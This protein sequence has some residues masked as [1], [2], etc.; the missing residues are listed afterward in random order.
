MNYSFLSIQRYPPLMHP[1]GSIYIPS[2]E[3]EGSSQIIS[4]HMEGQESSYSGL[5]EENSK[6]IIFIH[7]SRCTQD[8]ME[9]HWLML[10]FKFSS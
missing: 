5:I 3:N 9:Q 6:R 1:K 7:I 4:S 2:I 10:I 8:T